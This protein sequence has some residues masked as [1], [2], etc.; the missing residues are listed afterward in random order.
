MSLSAKDVDAAFYG[1]GQQV[2]L[3][4]WCVEDHGLAPVPKSSYGKFYTGSSYIIL[5]TVLLKSGIFQHDIHYWLGK[6]SKEVYC[7]LASDKAVELDTALGCRAVQYREVQG[8]ETV[9]FLSYFKPCIIPIEGVFSSKF[10]LSRNETYRICLLTCKGEHVV[11]VK[12]VPFTRSSLNHDD[13]FV[14]D[15][16]SKIFLFSGCNSSIQE[17]AKALEVVQYIKDHNHNG[18][19]EVATVEDGKFVGDSDV[20]EFWTFFGG[21]APLAKDPTHVSYI[22]PKVCDVKLHWIAKGEAKFVA[23]SS[24][25][26]DMLHTDKCYMLDCGAEIF[27]WMGSNTSLTERKTS[28]SAMEDIVHSLDRSTNSHVIFLTEGSETAKF[29]SY[30]VAWPTA[31]PNLYQEGKGKVAAMF[32]QQGFEVK[33][34]PEEDCQP[35]IDCTGKIQVWR[36]NL[37]EKIPLPSTENFKFYTGECYI[38]QYTYPGEEREEYLFYLW[39]GYN[40]ILEERVEAIS[41]MCAMADSLKGQAVLAQI[42]EAMEPI[43]FFLI[44]QSLIVFK[45]GMSSGYKRYIAQNKIIDETYNKSMTALFRIQGSSVDSMQAI[46]VDPVSS[47]LNSSYCYIVQTGASFFTWTGNLSSPKD[48]DLLDRMLDHINPN[49]QTRP[50]R[51]GSE[52]DNFWNA[53]G[54]K[55]DYS[56]EREIRKVTDDPHLFTCIFSE[57][58]LKVNEIFN[59]SQD[60]LMTEDVIVLDCLSEIFVWIGQSSNFTAKRQAFLV[61]EKFLEL[62][63]FLERRSLKTPI[64]AVM[65]GYEPSLFTRFFPWDFSKASM[66]GSSFDRKLAMVKGLHPKMTPKSSRKVYGMHST[67]STPDRSR[68]KSVSSER[69]R[70]VRSKSPAL[71]A[72]ASRFETSNGRGLSTPPPVVRKLFP[73][74]SPESS[75][76]KETPPLSPAM[77]ALP[78]QSQQSKSRAPEPMK[79]KDVHLNMTNGKTAAIKEDEAESLEAKEESKIFTY[80]C[81]KVSS[82]GP[83]TDIDVTRR[84][85]YLSHEEFQERFGMTK[86]AFYQLPKWKMNKQKLALDL[87]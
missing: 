72:M 48:Q 43:E 4:I 75:P 45:G 30:F 86:K 49:Q 47:S 70:Q 59:F 27:V 84:E 12:E 64:Y 77:A 28:I 54:G 79:A 26:K 16:E 11:R 76:S 5:N 82:K 83:V 32:K 42:F 2:G 3:E 71:T 22:Q 58:V 33:E 35:F 9:K 51:E 31:Q 61:G 81:L 57:G 85:S 18:R 78:P 21:Y 25:K 14:L 67:E 8:H 53:L 6:D 36:V 73:R 19:C 56:R 66:L 44:I 62:D 52:P 10:G 20:G 38:V 29:R 41:L 63:I 69:E 24:L 17:R 74:S 65:E 23:D 13:V 39:V 50:I 68:S 46:Q 55:L 80:E 1:A 40:S 34:L 87:F 7:T 60:D 37:H 15:T